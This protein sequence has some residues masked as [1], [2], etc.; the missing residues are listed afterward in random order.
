[1]VTDHLDDTLVVELARSVVRDVAPQEL[2]M[3]RA[4][5]ALYLKDPAKA[6]Q[7]DSQ[8]KGGA[9]D[10]LGFGAG[11]DLTLV[12]P[13]ALAVATEVIKFLATEIARAAKAESA[14]IIQAQVRRLFSRFANETEAAAAGTGP[15]TL[16]R[17]Q[18]EQVRTIAYD[19]AC[20]LHLTADQ[21]RLLADSTVGGLAVA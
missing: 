7:P 11:I 16:T 9:D 14:P 5:S 17:Q 10:L 8:R 19:T 2:P 3:F 1:V 6:Q 15:A 13:V 4:N 20:R 12:T 21:A 18:L